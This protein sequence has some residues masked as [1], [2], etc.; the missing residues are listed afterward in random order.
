LLTTLSGHGLERPGNWNRSSGGNS[1]LTAGGL[2]FRDS[3]PHQWQVDVG[4]RLQGDR[5]TS[6]QGSE[7][8]VFVTSSRYRVQNVVE[9]LNLRAATRQYPF[10]LPIALTADLF[11]TVSD[12]QHWF[13][14]HSTS[15]DTAT[16]AFRMT[17][18][19]ERREYDRGGNVALGAGWGRV[20]DASA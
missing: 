16:R 5:Q 1:E 20:R 3:D 18:S 8:D 12:Q 6:Q 10:A 9:S 15:R 19:R 11:A 4:T 7:D 13:H 14:T 17:E 2:W